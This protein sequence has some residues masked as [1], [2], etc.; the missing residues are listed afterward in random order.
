MFLP[1][2]N[3]RSL[4]QGIIVNQTY[5]I[6]LW[7]L[8]EVHELFAQALVSTNGKNGILSAEIDKFDDVKKAKPI[9]RDHILS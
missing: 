7:H 9:N 6:L 2:E 4:V 3:M 8:F 1:R 5:S